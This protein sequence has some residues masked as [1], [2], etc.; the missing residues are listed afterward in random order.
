MR[1][2]RRLIAA[3]DLA[4]IGLPNLTA[5]EARRE[6]RVLERVDAR[7]NLIEIRRIARR[8]GRLRAYAHRVGLLVGRR[9]ADGR[10]RPD[11]RSGRRVGRH[12]VPVAAHQRRVHGAR[13]VVV[14]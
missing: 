4:A 13:R 5:R 2:G 3:V 1:R 7:A 10:R 11:C 6:H 8:V 9:D 14:T 12:L